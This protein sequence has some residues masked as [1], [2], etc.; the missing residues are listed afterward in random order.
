MTQFI[1]V[2]ATKRSLALR[3][4]VCGVGINDAW[5]LVHLYDGEIL[6]G[7]CPYY[8]SWLNMIKR[9]YCQ[10][11]KETHP[12][13][14]DCSA[15]KE[16]LLFSNFKEWMVTQDWE[17][18]QLDKDLIVAGNK[19]YGPD[20]C[21]FVS[22]K[23]NGILNNCAA[24]RGALPQGVRFDS[25]TGKYRSECR[26]D[27]RKQSI[28]YFETELEAEYAYLVFKADLIAV[29]SLGLE[30]IGNPI[31]FDALMRHSEL[32]IEAASNVY[33]KIRE[34]GNEAYSS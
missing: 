14:N 2:P 4:T 16:W 29:T 25:D 6:I 32:F 17:G 30:S 28:G 33:I 7:K 26:V 3:S 22:S 19:I 24:S 20:K 12:T 8:R 5:Y 15:V 31:L 13:Y 34:K 9:C 18:K 27:G 10:K 21:I 11:Y 23:I 1:E